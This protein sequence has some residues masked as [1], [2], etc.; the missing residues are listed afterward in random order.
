MKS[1]LLF[2]VLMAGLFAALTMTIVC[3]GGAG[4]TPDPPQ[5][6]DPP[7][8]HYSVIDLGTLPGGT[9]SMAGTISNNGVI[10]GSSTG[11]DGNS[12]AVIWVGEHILDISN[13]GLGGFNSGA[14][15]STPGV[16]VGGG[17]ESSVQDPNNENFCAYFSGLECLPYVWQSG[18]MA[19]L[20]LLGGYNGEVN[21]VSDNG[22]FVG[23]AENSTKDP[24]CLSTPYVNGV[25]PQILDFEAVIWNTATGQLR[26]LNPLSGDTVAEGFGI[27]H[28]GQ[29]VGGSGSC[30]D[31]YPPP[32]AAA[33]HAV[34]WDADGSVHDLGNLGGTANPN[35]L[36]S[37]NIAF[38]INDQGQV[39]GLSALP[40]GTTFHGFFWTQKTGMEDL[41]TLSGDVISAGLNMNGLGAVVG[42]SVDGP[43]ATGNPRAVVWQKGVITD[44]NTV[45]P[46]DTSLYLLTAFDINDAGQVVGIG[47]DPASGEVHAFL[48]SPNPGGGPAA[49]RA[50]RRQIIPDIVRENLQRRGLR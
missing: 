35:A 9:F 27:N 12:H 11:S 43:I 18:V 16:K 14:F 25:G 47:F 26:P 29:A 44:L 10:T 5:A 46:A 2:P 37:G 34:L 15:G 38:A 45:V 19:P 23:V 7:P 6:A 31:T 20:P 36:G 32:F 4:G 39:A 17:A 49:H 42:S 22:Q 28:K 33:Q 13:P 24:Q 48:A 50:E 40:G 8:T 21:L 3:C 41:G 30:A 1:R